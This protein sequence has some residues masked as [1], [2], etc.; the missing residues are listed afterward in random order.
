MKYQYIHRTILGVLLC[1]S[2]I[3]AFSQQCMEKKELD[4]ILYPDNSPIGQPFT[5]RQPY[6]RMVR[7]NSYEEAWSFWKKI[8]KKKDKIE[9]YE[10]GHY[11]YYQY[12]L[13]NGKGY[14]IFTNK[15][16]PGK[17]EVAVLWIKADSVD[18]KEIHFVETVKIKKMSTVF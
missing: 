2:C 10:N 6:I 1:F 9:K 4:R 5:S 8:K 14:L 18:I 7:V 13:S 12:P 17:N 3:V 11:V 15:V 16:K